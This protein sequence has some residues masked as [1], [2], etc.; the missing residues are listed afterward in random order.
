MW[1]KELENVWYVPYA[2]FVMQ[3]TTK[4][5]LRNLSFFCK[6][7]SEL[8]FF[9]YATYT[10]FL[11]RNLRGKNREASYPFFYFKKAR[12]AF[13]VTRPMLISICNLL[14]KK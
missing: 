9:R 5:K 3:P 8:R 4:K 11:I 2:F 6:R 1:K 10:F 7:K 12:C 14:P 13:L